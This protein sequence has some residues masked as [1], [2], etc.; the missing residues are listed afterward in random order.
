MGTTRSKNEFQPLHKAFPEMKILCVH[1]GAD[2]YGASRCLLRN[3]K[4]LSEDGHSVHIMLPCDG[5]LLSSLENLKLSVE[6]PKTLSL[7]TRDPLRSP[8]G[9]LC[10]LTGMIKSSFYLSCVIK[11]FRPDIIH[12]NTA[13]I[14]LFS[15]LA[16]KWHRVKHI[17]HIREFFTEFGP[18][19][20]IYKWIV[21]ALSDEIWTVSSAVAEQFTPNRLQRKVRVVHDGFPQE[22]FQS[23][24]E[25][26][27]TDFRTKYQLGNG[28]LIGI[29]GRIKFQRKGQ[30]IFVQAAAELKEQY[31]QIR[32]VIIGS[33]FPG[34]EDHL[35]KLTELIDALDVK[36]I[37]TYTGDVGDVK[38]AYSSLDIS[39]LASAL[40][41][42][43]GGVVIESMFL[44]KPVV[45]TRIGGT[46]EQIDDGKTGILVNPGDPEDLA[47][48]LRTFLDNPE[49]MRAMGKNGKEKVL[50]EYEFEKIYVQML[51]AYRGVLKS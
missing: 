48:A 32:Y 34:N 4:K 7:L 16:A 22:E 28:P 33:P 47:R 5:P 23:V 25:S 19:W 36:S 2:L 21:Y 15:G 49:R 35:D 1:S 44:G 50:R 29:V 8:W 24:S 40:P 43:F 13:T 11:K 51:D 10:L 31:P 41:E 18:L 39:V 46:I 37:V 17:W 20:N 45:G 27:I 3:C 14:F 30:E 12:S 9:I 42:P 38:A 26:R 6:I